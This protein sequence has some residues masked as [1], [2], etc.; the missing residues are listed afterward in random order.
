MLTNCNTRLNYLH[1]T[2]QRRCFDQIVSFLS[3]LIVFQISSGELCEFTMMVWILFAERAS[4]IAFA[5]AGRGVPH[6]SPIPLVP[7]NV[8]GERVSTCP[9]WTSQRSAAVGA[10]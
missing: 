3:D 2:S 7:S 10:R 8:N 5:M 1:H 4:S 6:P 9:T